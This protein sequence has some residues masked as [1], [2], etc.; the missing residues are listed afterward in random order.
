MSGTIKGSRDNVVR[1]LRRVAAAATV[2]AASLGLL[3][4]CSS[5]FG[6]GSDQTASG[7]DKVQTFEPAE[8]KAEATLNIASGSENK[9]VADAIQKAVDDSGVAV[10]MNYMGSLDIMGALKN[11]GDTYDAVWPAS[12]MWISMGDT[13]HIVKDAASTSTTPIVF[14]IAKSK[15]EQLGWADSSGKTQS[16]KTADILAAVSSGKLKF[17]MTSATQSNSGAS[18]YLAFMTALTGRDEPLTAADLN[19]TTLT[20]QVAALLKGVDRSSG[21]SD[22][23]KDMVVASPDRFDSM[24]N[25]ESLVIQADKQLTKAGHD[26]LVAIYPADGIAVSDSPLGYVDRGQNLEDAFAK[27][28]KALSSKD[29]KLLFERAGRRTGLGGALAYGSDS[30]VQQSFRA[31]WGINTSADTLKTIALPSAS[32]IDQALT[33][34]Q[35]KLRKPSYTIWV[36]DYSG[37]MNGEGKDGVVSGLTSALDPTKSAQYHIEPSGEDVNVLIP[38]S[39]TAETPVTAHGTDTGELL[40]QAEER[41]ATGGT[42]I[43]DG[44][45]SAF[46][47]LPS[48]LDD[49][50]TAVVLMTDG[51]SSTSSRQ[52]FTDRYHAS[53]HDLPIF[54]IMFG[55]ADPAQLNELAKLSNAKVFDGRSGDLAAVFRQVKGFN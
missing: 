3:A 52:S 7:S 35:T 5:P 31:E 41:A 21:S 33:V 10:T 30:Q 18:A 11:G 27:F 22:W 39:S 6:N 50:T 34:Y 55:D 8:G 45:N 9:E 49:Y 16:V 38:F 36:V 32:V 40:R 44:L 43:Y 25:Y 24:V 46:S 47:I 37:S 14:G 54:S 15:A 1:L 23:L 28:Q 53:G 2:A 4:A 48:N 13:K 19:D 29:S 17:S 12:S 51:Q 42:N 26:P 20:N